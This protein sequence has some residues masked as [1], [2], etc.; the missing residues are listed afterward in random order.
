L[1]AGGPVVVPKVVN[2]RN[3]VFWFF[4]FE[5]VKDSQPATT[6]ITVPTAAER[7]GDFSALLGVKSPTILYDPYT[8]VMSGTTVTRSAYPGNKIPSNQLSPIAQKYLQFF[9]E[10]NVVNGARD[11]GFNNF[12]TNASSSDGYTNELGRLDFNFSQKHR[13]Y[14]N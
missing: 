8:A 10:P 3:R 14:F 6:F 2:G 13:T 11:D 7:T 1:V 5:G 9:P 4:A 12:G